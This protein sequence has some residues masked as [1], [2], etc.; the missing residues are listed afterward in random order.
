MGFDN[1][2]LIGA[3]WGIRLAGCVVILDLRLQ[4][5]DCNELVPIVKRVVRALAS[6]L[7][8][9]ETTEERLLHR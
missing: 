3:L 2:L 8:G 5:C 9:T 6:N 7:T 4:Q 1:L